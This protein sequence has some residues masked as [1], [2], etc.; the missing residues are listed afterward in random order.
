MDDLFRRSL[1]EVVDCGMEDFVAEAGKLNIGYVTTLAG[2]LER[3][4][5]DFRLYVEGLSAGGMENRD[6]ILAAYTEMQ[7]IENKVVWL[8][9]REEALRL[10]PPG[11][12][13]RMV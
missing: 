13:E 2:L 11:D 4:Y 9:A 10:P 8:R 1:G 12:G 6:A 3:L 5:H 7:K